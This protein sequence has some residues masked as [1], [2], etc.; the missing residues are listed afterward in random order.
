M[1]VVMQPLL[2]QRPDFLLAVEHVAVEHCRAVSPIES[3]DVGFLG[4]L[5]LL[6]Q[7]Q[8]D[9]PFSRPCGEFTA[10]KLRPVVHPQ[11]LRFTP[12][13]DQF[14]EGPDHAFCRQAADQIDEIESRS[15]ATSGSVAR[16]SSTGSR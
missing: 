1:V 5:A 15:P 11:A 6:D 7:L 4:R 13:F 12:Q 8:G 10:D 16:V 14:G 3:L 9:A 2:R